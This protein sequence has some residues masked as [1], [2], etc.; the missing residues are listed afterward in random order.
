MLKRSEWKR[1]H[2][3][4]IETFLCDTTCYAF[5]C[6]KCIQR[7]AYYCYEVVLFN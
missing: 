3:R 5:Y 6:M 7:S 4:F 1:Q 2:P